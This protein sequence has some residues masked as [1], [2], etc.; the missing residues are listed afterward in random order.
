MV[1]GIYSCTT[2]N[3]PTLDMTAIME[4]N[5][6][7]QLENIVSC[8]QPEEAALLQRQKMLQVL[9]VKLAQ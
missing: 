5:L 7:V 2:S 4:S 1:F 9:G 3:Q 6:A 8:D